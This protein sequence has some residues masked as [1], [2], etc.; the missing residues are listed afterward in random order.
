MHPKAQEILDKVIGQITGYKNP[1]TV[2]G[3]MQKYAFDV[4]LPV[5]VVDSVTSEITW[6]QSANPAKFITMETAFKGNPH[7]GKEDWMLEK[8]DIKSINDVLAIWQLTNYTTTQRK[9][10]SLEVYESDNVYSSENVHRSQDIHNSKNIL[11]CDTIQ[12]GCEYVV[13]SQR[14][15]ASTYC[16][17]LEDSRG[18]SQSFNVSWSNKIVNSAFIHDSFD[19]YECLFCS[20]LTSRKYCVANMQFEETEYFAIKKMVMEW[21][22]TN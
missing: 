15:Q 1:Y 11:L 8:Q 20:H 13:A 6:A 7:T 3:F 12:E 21:I 17:R 5:Q 22:L 4:R 9:L 19:L 2:E 14:S 10:D 18:C 16:A